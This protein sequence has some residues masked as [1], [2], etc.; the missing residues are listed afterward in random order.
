VKDG[1]II[2]LGGRTL[3]VLYTPGHL[4]SCIMLLD[5]DN[6]LLFTGDMYYPGPLLA[7][8][9]DSSFPDYVISMRKVADLAASEKIEWLFCSHNYMEKGTDHLSRLADFLEGIQSGEITDCKL[10]DDSLCNTMDDEISI[11]LPVQ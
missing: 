5:S 3:E 11:Y 9:E 7:M 2:D 4:S 10:E 6:K 8:F 1:Q